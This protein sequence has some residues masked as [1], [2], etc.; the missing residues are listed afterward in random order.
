VKTLGGMSP[1]SSIAGCSCMF[2]C[3]VVRVLCA[4]RQVRV[5]GATSELFPHGNPQLQRVR[6]ALPA[7]ALG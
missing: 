4:L 3:S 6:S 7:V 2:P 1:S 5:D